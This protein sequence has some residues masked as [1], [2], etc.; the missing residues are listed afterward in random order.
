MGWIRTIPRASLKT[1]ARAGALAAVGRYQNQESVPVALQVR[2]TVLLRV[3][4]P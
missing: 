3:M 2:R 4:P 1:A